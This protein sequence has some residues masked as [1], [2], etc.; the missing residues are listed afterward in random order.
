MSEFEKKL[1]EVKRHWPRRTGDG[2]LIVMR[3]AEWA[4]IGGLKEQDIAEFCELLSD[5]FDS[6]FQNGILAAQQ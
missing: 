6:S 3:L 4:V 2:D 1:E 5:E